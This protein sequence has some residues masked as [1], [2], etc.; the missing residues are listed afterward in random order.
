MLVIDAPSAKTFSAIR[1]VI[2]AVPPSIAVQ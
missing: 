1:H 2:M